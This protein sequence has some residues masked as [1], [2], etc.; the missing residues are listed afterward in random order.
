M[1]W[2]NPMPQ[3]MSSKLYFTLWTSLEVQWLILHA[4]N[5]WDMG[6]IPGQGTKIPSCHTAPPK[7]KKKNSNENFFYIVCLHFPKYPLT[8]PRIQSTCLSKSIQKKNSLPIF[9]PNPDINY[10]V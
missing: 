9:Q 2:L 4:A 5:A 8:A 7:K 1:A 6:L 10:S 3:T